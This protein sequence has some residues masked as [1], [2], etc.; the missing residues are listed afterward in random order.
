MV[1]IGIQMLRIPFEWLELAFEWFES[2]QMVG[3]SIWMVRIS[4]DLGKYFSKV[5]ATQFYSFK[6]FSWPSAR[7]CDSVT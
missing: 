4:F 3:I 2:I 1:G 7:F 6:K 5:L